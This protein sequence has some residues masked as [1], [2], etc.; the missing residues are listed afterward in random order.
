[1]ALHRLFSS[2]LASS[3]AQTDVE[4]LTLSASP[5]GEFAETFRPAP[6]RRCDPLHRV[7]RSRRAVIGFDLHKGVGPMTSLS[8]RAATAPRGATATSGRSAG[9]VARVRAMAA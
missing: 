5:S 9:Q 8:I 4:V 6:A 3:F 1:M 2:R 7:S